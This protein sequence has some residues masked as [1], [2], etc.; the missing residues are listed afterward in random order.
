MR[1]TALEEKVAEL[2]SPVLK[3]LGLDLLWVAYK[4]GILGVF[5]ENPKTG[6]LTLKECTDISREISPLLEVEDLISSAYRLE[7]S[8]AGIDRP[9]FKREDYDR[10]HDLEAKVEMDMLIDGKKKFRGVIR[11]TTEEVVE[12]ETDEGLVDLPFASIYK[13]KLIMTDELIK[14]TKKRFETAN[15][16]DAVEIDINQTTT[17][18]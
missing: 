10:F 6:K 3:D 8:S 1:P 17:V 15:E 14:E 16:N 18:N 7:V 2:I 4:G 5:A 13:A 11:K 9:L 12:L